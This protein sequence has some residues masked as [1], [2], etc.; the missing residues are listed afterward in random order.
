VPLHFDT[1]KKLELI[2]PT[3]IYV[4][5]KQPFILFFDL[6]TPTDAEREDDI[7]KKVWSFDNSPIIFIIKDKDI[8][9]YN[10]LNYIKKEKR[11]QKIHFE[12]VDDRNKQFSFWNL[13]SGCTWKWLQEKYLIKHK[14]KRVNEKLFQNIE[15]VRNALIDKETDPEGSIPNALIL[16][17]IFIRYLIDRGIKID[18]RYIP[19]NDL[20]SKR[21]NFSN[22]IQNP[23]K[24]G[25]LFTLLNSKFNGV[26]F[27]D[28]DV[29]LSNVEAKA[30]AQIFKG[31][32]PE[33]G[34]LFYDGNFY[35]DIFDFSI[36]PV[37]VISGIYESLIN[38][39]TKDLNAAVY[40]PAFLAE[41]VL[42]DTVD[43][44]L[45][46]HNVSECK[47]FEVAVGSGIFLVQS[48]RKMIE[49][50][51][52]LNGNENKVAFS[53]KIRDIAKNNLFGIDINAEALKVACFSIYIAL[54]DY[55]DP[56][57]ID[58]YMFPDLL[59]KN[60]FKADFFDTEHIYNK[61]I[62]SKKTN[63]ILGNP[64]WKEDKSKKHLEWL[65]KEN[66]YNKKIIGK[67]EIAQ[68]FLL[69]TKDF[70]QLDTQAALIVTSTIFYN[71]STTTRI[72][73]NKFLNTYCLDKFFDLSPVRRL[74]FEEKNSP[75]SIVYFRL[76][77]EDEHLKNIVN[78]QSVKINY[79]L[80]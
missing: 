63:F 51:K 12:T 39:E 31:E 38:P 47:I 25:K 73:K 32:K 52:E 1:Q 71:V 26:L 28:I 18:E 59:E 79:F 70:M 20:S 30:L 11:L 27:K 48:L 4:F 42:N 65:N 24:L 14:R 33:E 17:L 78:H 43:K 66:I 54:L 74:I 50:E 64:P 45:Y 3:A 35:F 21:S 2:Q 61:T 62:K 9:V 49:K 29:Q 19:G 67:I 7:H 10:A 69:R 8:S 5:N 44:F 57:D 13:Q 77:K 72:F 16:R 23:V 55:Q 36:I 75:A 76:S 40:T 80:K 60:L 41:Y 68:S 56:K 53:E 15:D 37:E 34:S 46:E 58:T 22:L 6:T